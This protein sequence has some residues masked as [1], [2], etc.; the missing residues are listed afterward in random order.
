MGLE[1]FYVVL[2][3]S[4]QLKFAVDFRRKNGGVNIFPGSE[5]EPQMSLLISTF[6]ST[7]WWNIMHANYHFY[8]PYAVFEWLIC[9]WLEK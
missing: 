3:K 9:F 2:R 1:F 6:H 4:L 7:E 5:T 8:L